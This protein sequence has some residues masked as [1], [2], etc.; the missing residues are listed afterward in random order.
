MKK[1]I[2][3][4][5][6]WLFALATIVFGVVSLTDTTSTLSLN[7]EK[8]YAL[9]RQALRAEVWAPAKHPYLYFKFTKNQRA[10][11]AN[12]AKKTEGVSIQISMSFSKKRIKAGETF[13]F[14]FGLLYEDDFASPNK[15]KDQIEKRPLV[16]ADFATLGTDAF[17]VSMCTDRKMPLGFFVYGTRK[18]S[19]RQV[20]FAVAEIG[21]SRKT[22][23]PLFAFGSGGG[24]V[25]ASFTHADFSAA[26]SVFPVKNTNLTV[27]PKI[28]IEFFDCADNGLWNHQEHVSF[29]A[30]GEEFAV[31]RTLGKQQVTVQTSALHKPF[32]RV[33][34]SHNAGMVASILMT[35]ND[36]ALV[37]ASATGKTIVPFKTDL[38]FVYDWPQENWRCA[39]YEL[40]SWEN[41]PQVLFFDT[42][43]Y[44][45]QN[46]FFTRLAYFVEKA[47]YKGTLVSDYVVETQHG[48]N[49]H[50]YKDV[51]LAAFYTAASRAQFQLNE[52][53]LLLKNILVQN[54]IIIAKDD[55]TFIAGRGAVISISRE[56]PAYLRT[57]FVA[58]ESWHG[59]YFTDE[60][61]R[62]TVAASYL[63]FD[64]QSMRFIK[65]FWST[66][67]G[68]QYDL[69]DDY[70]MKNEFMAYLMQQPLSRTKTYF[71]QVAGRGSVNQIEP[72]LAAYVRSTDAAAFVDAAALLNDYAFTRWGLAA[73]RV[74]LVLR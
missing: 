6:I 55:G 49:A 9:N 59:I 39:D 4:V 7:G 17:S 10:R 53:E 47:G 57:T 67:P 45:V 30:G 33:D 18:F 5:C 11:L 1:T 48:Y 56:S 37:S 34:I 40:Y 29:V 26:S 42:V 43:S 13:P 73:G 19:V 32:D 28:E 24:V 44:E 2:L 63:M 38:G 74:G 54:K 70:L 15:L 65:T 35:S 71:L 36:E 25:D 8:L 66:Q 20:E 68:L 31:R 60:D 50:D 16:T 58:H 52:Y 46:K 3:F 64:E 23:V 41:F 61:F 51:D 72:E 21:W 69:N 27:M 12:L 22:E 62:N 14:A